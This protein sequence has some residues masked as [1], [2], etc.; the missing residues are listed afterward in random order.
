M[1]QTRPLR[2]ARPSHLWRNGPILVCPL[3]LMSTTIREQSAQSAYRAVRSC[4]ERLCDPM[5]VEDMVVSSMPDVSPTKWHLAHT[6]WFFE[7]FILKPHLPD[8]REIDPRYAFLFNSYYEA[9]EAI[10]ATDPV[11]SPTPAG[12]RR[13]C[14]SSSAV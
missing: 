12:S 4:T 11:V 1:D 3:S 6:S 5:E 8:Y 2:Q 14:R 10:T 7:T 13:G 9:V